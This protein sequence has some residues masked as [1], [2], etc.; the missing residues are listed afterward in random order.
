MNGK[1]NK[2]VWYQQNIEQI[3]EQKKEYYQKKAE[4]I[5]EKRRARYQQQKEQTTS[6][7]KRRKKQIYEAS[8]IRILMSLRRYTEL[9][10][11]KQKLWAD[12]CWTLKDTNEG[13]HDIADIMK[14]RESA[15][16]LI[17]DYWATA[18]REAAEGKHWSELNHKQQEKLITY[19]GN[20]KAREEQEI[21]EGIKEI[22][23]RGEEA[24]KEIEMAKFH[25][26][27]GKIKC[28]CWQ[29]QTRQEIRAEVK[30][31]QRAESKAG[32]KKVKCPEC[33]KLVKKLDEESGVCKKCE[34]DYK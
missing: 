13:I 15:D 17:R 21:K 25:E 7:R 8:S 16:N 32:I 12:F 34:G 30:K 20:E 14:L 24:Q 4:E 18:K 2:K 19:W 33:S 9:T 1:E 29:C 11:E 26:E 22:V 5:K 28:D 3:R 23:T 6:Q 27:R 10:A 31:E